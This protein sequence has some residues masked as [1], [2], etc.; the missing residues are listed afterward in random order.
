MFNTLLIVF[1]Q[2]RLTEAILKT[3]EEKL[4]PN[5]AI[6]DIAI[7]QDE[8]FGHYQCNSALSLAKTL[9][10]SPRNIA[11]RRSLWV[12]HVSWLL[13][14]EGNVHSIKPLLQICFKVASNY[15]LEIL[16]TRVSL[17]GHYYS[18]FYLCTEPI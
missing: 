11:E 10:T 9:Q 4:S 5:L 12:S 15:N 13:H 18:S 3:F 17:F 14:L 1:L 2:N 8:K 6:A 16:V 7:C